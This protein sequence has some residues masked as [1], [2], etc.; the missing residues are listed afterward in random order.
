MEIPQF[1]VL[2]QGVY[3]VGVFHILQVY[4]WDDGGRG[5]THGLAA[6]LYLL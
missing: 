5:C 3:N 1:L 4:F 2:V 6:G